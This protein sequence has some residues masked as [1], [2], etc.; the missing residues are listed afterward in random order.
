M[1]AEQRRRA[2][3]ALWA[4]K[5]TASEQAQVALLIAKHLKFRPKTVMGLDADRKTRYLASVP[6]VP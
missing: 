6:E 3:A 4:T 5:E 1:T 2:G